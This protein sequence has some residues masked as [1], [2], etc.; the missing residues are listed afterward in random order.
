MV[1]RREIVKLA[2]KAKIRSVELRKDP[3]TI[4]WNRSQIRIVIWNFIYPLHML[5]FQLPHRH[6]IQLSSSSTP[7][8]WTNFPLSVIRI[9]SIQHCVCLWSLKSELY[10]ASSLLFYSL[11]FSLPQN[12]RVAFEL[13][14]FAIFCSLHILL[15]TFAFY[16]TQAE[17]IQMGLWG[18]KR[19][20]C[21]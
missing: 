7:H 16:R 13:K 9:L 18:S 8:N 15:N 21:I 10:F 20:I 4:C 19:L 1:S 11:P 3:S 12:C 17:C 6:H 2:R 5:I 14:T